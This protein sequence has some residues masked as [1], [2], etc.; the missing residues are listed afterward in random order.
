MKPITD[1]THEEL[2]ALTEEQVHKYI[3]LEYA[4]KGVPLEAHRPV[5]PEPVNAGPDDT[6]YTVAGLRFSDRDYAEEAADFLNRIPRL[7]TE[8]LVYSWREPWRLVPENDELT[9]QTERHWTSEHYKRHESALTRYKEEKEE[10]DRALREFES[11]RDARL[12]AQ[13][14]VRGLV[15]EARDLERDREAVRSQFQEYLNLADGDSA[16]AL[17]FL[18]KATKHD[19]QF[20]C[21]TLKMEEDHGE[22]TV[23]EYPGEG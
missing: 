22:E 20:V 16:M 1:L 9:V 7:T 8:G 4:E 19:E 3:Q 21:E 2:L 23:T 10:Y 14:L 17:R 11:T 6:C 15:Q 5:P 13:K 12:E 18:L